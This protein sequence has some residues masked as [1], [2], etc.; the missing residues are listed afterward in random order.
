MDARLVAS[1]H[2]YTVPR[3][4]ELAPASLPGSPADEPR[5]ALTQRELVAASLLVCP[6]RSGAAAKHV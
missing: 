5:R 1:H 3:V 6:E 2:E 4:R